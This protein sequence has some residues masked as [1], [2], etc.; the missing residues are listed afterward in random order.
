MK[1]V[2]QGPLAV[3]RTLIA[4]LL[5]VLL[6]TVPAAGQPA[7][8]VL[9][10]FVGFNTT[11]PP[12]SDVLARRAVAAAID[13]GRIAA[14]GN[15][16]V[17]TGVE[18]PGCLGHNPVPRTLQYSP[19]AA[20]DL[21][22]QSGNKPDE[23]GELGLWYLSLLTQVDV[24]RQELDI[25]SANL[26]AVGL[27]VTLREFGNYGAFDRIA[28]LPVVKMSYWGIRWDTVGCSRGTF[29]EAL[30]HSKGEFNRFG[31]RNPEIDALI[32][33]ARAVSDRQTKSRLFQ[34]AER[35]LLDDA[36]L[37]PVWWFVGR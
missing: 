26:S 7:A 31:Y 19:Q 28:T 29:L 1:W 36:V 2:A 12:F 20:R 13:R 15:N 37:V 5:A 21:L 18:P 23:L 11:I 4:M 3:G 17:A 8:I 33:R 27:R 9:V 25:L 32:E 35:R 30:V 16:A 6:L 34:E 24:L 10:W 14:A 22:A